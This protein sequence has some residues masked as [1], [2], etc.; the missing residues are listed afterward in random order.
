MT[1]GAGKGRG[2]DYGSN[3]RKCNT[4]YRLYFN[5]RRSSGLGE[6]LQIEEKQKLGVGRVARPTGKNWSFEKLSLSLV[7]VETGSQIE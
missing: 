6:G 4:P 7:K 3:F 5:E 1:G 2:H